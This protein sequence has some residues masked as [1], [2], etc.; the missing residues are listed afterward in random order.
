MLFAV[1]KQLGLRVRFV[2][3]HRVSTGFG[4]NTQLK[5][6]WL[7]QQKRRRE[8]D[9]AERAAAAAADVLAPLAEAE[10][11][12]GNGIDEEDILLPH[13]GAN[14]AETK[15]NIDTETCETDVTAPLSPWQYEKRNNDYGFSGIF[16]VLWGGEDVRWAIDGPTDWEVGKAYVNVYG[17]NA[18]GEVTYCAAG[19]LVTV[20]GWD[21]DMR[22]ALKGL[23]RS[24]ENNPV[25]ATSKISVS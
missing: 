13:G 18:S 17:N 25:R 6:E 10:A 8:R 11:D 14:T 2:H 23:R 20:P 7:A 5:D 22:A 1:V 16:P 21:D 12:A 4:T 24:P 19:I 9:E 15:R 3:L